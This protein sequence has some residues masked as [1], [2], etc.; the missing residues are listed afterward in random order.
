[1]FSALVIGV[2]ISHVY[3]CI[4]Q[5]LGQLRDE[6]V[7][8]VILYCLHLEGYSVANP[9]IGKLKGNNPDVISKFTYQLD[10]LFNLPI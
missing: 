2:I 5:I 10:F 4:I 3:Y 6:L 7:T 8:N 1:M 9:R